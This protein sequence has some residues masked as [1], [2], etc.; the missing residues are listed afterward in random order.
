[1]RPLSAG[2]GPLRSAC[3]GLLVAALALLVNGTELFRA[4][5]LRTVDLRYRLRGPR[6]VQ[7]PVGV[8]FIGDDSVAAYGRWPWSWEYH[9]L[10]VDA[11]RRAGARLVLF[12]VLFSEAPSPAD[13]WL[14]A[15]AARQAGNVH[16]ISSFTGDGLKTPAAGA[17]ERL[18]TGSELT[19]PLPVLRAAVAGIGHA[20]AVRD[21]D[22]A[23]RRIPIAVRRGGA[24]Y[25]SA[26]LRASAAALGAREDAIRV[27]AGGDLELQLHGRPPVL[28][29]VDA[30]GMTP[31]DF[32]GGLEAF[33]V[34][35]S[36]RQVLEAD[37]H[38][39]A[40]AV[41]LG[42][43]RDRIVVVGVSFT[44]NVDLQPTPFSTIY[45]MFLIQATMIDTILR[46]EFP[47]RTPP[48]F[49]VAVCLLLGAGLGA[50]TFRV[51]PLASLGA[52]ALAGGGYAAGAVLAFSHGGWLLPLLAPLSTVLAA[53]LLVTTVQYIEARAEKQRAL[54]R[55]RYLGHL[56]ESASE[57]IFSFDPAGRIASW[58][59]GAAR[60]YGWT[61]A[62]AL[63]RDWTFLLTPEAR[64]LVEE[65][66][67]ILATGAGGASL[68][69]QLLGRDGRAIPVQ[70]AFSTIRNSADAEVGT[71]A[72]SEDLTE[73]KHML[74]V[75]IQS[76]KLAEIGRM[77]SGIVHEIK[78]PLTSIMMMSDI[79]VGTK[80][81]PEKTLRYAD[82]IQ[83][84]S[85][86]ILRLSQNILS[87]ARPQKPE[88]KATDVNRVLE[89]TLGLVEYELKKA[90]VRVRTAFDA[91]VPPAW[92]DG[93]KL[94]Q[95]FL[96]L[97]VNASHALTDGG[98][99]E[100]ST[101]G[102]GGAPPPPPGAAEWS[103]AA[104][105]EMPPGPSVTVR[106]AD[107]G[108]GIP[109]PILAKIFEPFFSTK[110][111][112]KGTGLGLYISRNIVLE[113]HG[114]IEVASALGLGTVFTIVLPARPAAGSDGS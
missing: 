49:S 44:G 33:P 80:D 42:A 23:T 91:G 85:Q 70:I 87:F 69:T 37:A 100:V 6:T 107:H 94:K 8:V 75:L 14:L 66:L 101:F 43:L 13:A 81:L 59:A 30:D 5:E 2:R 102:P 55:L 104:V 113:H 10:L 103:R 15:A 109:E 89:D 31:V 71:S 48:W 79:I 65:A 17:G 60:V 36:Y 68:E 41:D 112:G 58:N 12:D 26:A 98:K 83:K 67:A 114:L 16:L 105:G 95:V 86:R 110:G 78:N 39:A 82:I 9:A 19:E 38:P 54:E 47:R 27:T 111:E 53:Y 24:L 20:N 76:E 92:G 18:L 106:I 40:A 50:L 52:A 90:K 22:G 63:G 77:G 1:M 108:T 4:F 29:P 96:N 74:E 34:K 84:E 3:L 35:Y 62:E 51:R 97:I 25:P 73:K 28:I 64:P 32:A 46:G 99:L 88:M 61:E 57:A 93:E 11:L 7:S 56:V 21:P 45:P 72:I